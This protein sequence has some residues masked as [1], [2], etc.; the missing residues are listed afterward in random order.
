MNIPL[1]EELFN[2]VVR[3]ASR[4]FMLE[5]K[6]QFSE[7]PFRRLISQRVGLPADGIAYKVTPGAKNDPKYQL[8]EVQKQALDEIWQAQITSR[9]DLADY[10]ALRSALQDLHKPD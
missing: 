6:E 9:F 2:I 10:A 7:A 4:E 3:Q 5:H 1:D 8:T